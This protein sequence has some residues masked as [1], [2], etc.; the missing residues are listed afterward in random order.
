MC[1]ARNAPLETN[2]SRQTVSQQPTS[3][4]G[5]Y[6][7]QLADASAQV[8]STLSRRPHDERMR[9]GLDSVGTEPP[10]SLLTGP[11]GKPVVTLARLGVLIRKLAWPRA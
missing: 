3:E 1:P 4:V 6:E 5:D 7:E 11:V 8:S 10:A 2:G 9:P